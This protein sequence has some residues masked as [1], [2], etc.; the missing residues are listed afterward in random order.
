MAEGRLAIWRCDATTPGC[1]TDVCDRNR[2]A[3][4]DYP[5]AVHD[6]LRCCRMLHCMLHCN[7]SLQRFTATLHCSTSLQR[8]TA[9]LHCNDPQHDPQQRFTARTAAHFTAS[10]SMFYSKPPLQTPRHASSHK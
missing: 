1:Q 8:F 3:L 6:T 10:V 9:T 5:I 7:A 2:P 4:P